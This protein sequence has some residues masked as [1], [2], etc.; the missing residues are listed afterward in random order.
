[1]KLINFVSVRYR[2]RIKRFVNNDH[3]NVIKINDKI[4]ILYRHIVI[5]IQYVFLILEMNTVHIYTVCF[6]QKLYKYNKRLKYLE[7]Y[8]LLIIIGFKQTFNVGIP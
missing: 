8:S 6:K 7:N 1:L 3:F 5:K 4:R 2:N